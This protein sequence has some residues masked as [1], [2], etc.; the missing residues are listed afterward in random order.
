MGNTQS[1]Y[2]PRTLKPRSRRNLTIQTAINPLASETSIKLEGWTG[3]I[4]S[5]AFVKRG[6]EDVLEVGRVSMLFK[7]SKS[8]G[9]PSFEIVIKIAYRMHPVSQPSCAPSSR[10]V[11]RLASRLLRALKSSLLG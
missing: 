3:D 7:S 2:V 4:F 8:V 9:T 5:A 11:G 6:L 1:T 10:D